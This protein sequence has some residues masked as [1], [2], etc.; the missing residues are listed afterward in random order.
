MI[1]KYHKDTGRDSRLTLFKDGL[2]FLRKYKPDEYDVIFMDIDMPHINGID[3][4]RR[5][6][7]SDDR[8]T[9]VFMTNLRQYALK[10]YEVSALDFLVKPIGYAAFS[11]MMN[12][13]VKGLRDRHEPEIIINNRNG[14]YRIGMSDI[15]YLEVCR[16]Y[17]IY[18]TVEG[19]IEV[20]GSLVEE[21]KKLTP[22][23]FARCNNCFLVNLDCV[24]EVKGDNVIVGGDELKISRGKKV[25]FL[26]RLLDH[27]SN[28]SGGGR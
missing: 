9:L 23:N 25:D 2:D 14:F 21:E 7:K 26:K 19:N 22:D 3:T 10:G 27:I 11:T 17:V 12:R 15:Y 5:L 8:V 6:R 16:H 4:A 1:D 20:W 24:K 18:H 13:V 28:G